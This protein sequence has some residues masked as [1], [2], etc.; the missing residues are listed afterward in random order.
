M[1]ALLSIKDSSN[2]KQMGMDR[3]AIWTAHQFS[4]EW[5]EQLI[6]KQP[7]Q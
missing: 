5:K 6:A 3:W 1:Q 4:D 2:D 7:E